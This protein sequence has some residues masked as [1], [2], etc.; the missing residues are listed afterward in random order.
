[1]VSGILT[2]A[3]IIAAGPTGE[4]IGPAIAIQAGKAKLKQAAIKEAVKKANARK[5]N[6]QLGKAGEKAVGLTGAKK[7]ILVNGRTR[8]PDGLSRTT[9][10]EVK[11]TA[12][13]SFTRQLRDFA[14][15]AKKNNIDFELFV[16]P[17]A[18]LSG[19]LQEAVKRGDII[20][21]QIPK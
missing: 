16:R 2:V 3:D 8:I 20:L 18:K 10:T 9:L 21:R 4:G 1:V 12:S 6:Q 13:Q 15:F 19:P 11:N 14:D 17:G 7:R 5:L